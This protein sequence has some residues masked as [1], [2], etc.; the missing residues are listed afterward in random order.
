M[1][2]LSII[3]FRY[4]KSHR[5]SLYAIM[6]ISMVL[7]AVL[8][9]RMVFEED[10]TKLLPSTDKGGSEKL[11]F[12]NLKVKDKLFITISSLSG[13]SQ[14]EDMAEVCDNF[15]TSLIESD[16]I[17]NLIDNVLY[18]ID[19]DLIPDA[20]SFLYDNIASFIPIDS[21]DKIEALLSDSAV[22]EQMKKNKELL[23]SAAGTQMSDLVRTDP[24][25]IRNI[26][27]PQA[28]SAQSMSGSDY[29]I[30]DYHFYTSDT[31]VNIAFVS[32]AFKSF[33][34][35]SGIRLIELIEEQIRKYSIEYPDME[36][37]YHGAPGQSVFN[38]RQIKKDLALT[39]SVSM[40]II[41][42][43]IGICFKNRST[44]IML[45][46]PV[47]YGA[48]FALAVI[49]IIKGSMSLMALGIGAIVL[50]VALSYCLHVLTHYKYVSDHDVVLKD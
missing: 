33:D 26:F 41:C 39:L 29:K 6:I 20:V 43:I 36:I 48:L 9:S 23:V 15:A 8:G 34:S 35:K 27:L 32:P 28:Q 10:I 24:V 44:L 19:E 2:K 1:T 22:E 3:I 38:S 46:A 13:E 50:G 31:T 42:I 11:V 5:I 16:T 17:Y 12:S 25:G 18:N 4:F 47:L 40:L 14:P 49:Y 30:Y 45:V 21:Y 37:L 7:F